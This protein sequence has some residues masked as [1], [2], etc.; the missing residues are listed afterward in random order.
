M[1]LEINAPKTKVMSNNT[2]LDA[3]LTVTGETLECVDSLTYLGSVI[4]RDWNVQKDIN[5]RLGKAM[6]AFANLR[7]L[8]LS[9]V[10]SIRIKLNLYDSIVKSVLLYGSEYWQVVETDFHK[11][12]AFHN[13]CLRMI[14]RILWSR[15]ISNLELYAKK[16]SEP[17]QATIKKRRLRWL[18]QFLRMSQNRI[19]RVALRCMFWLETM[20]IVK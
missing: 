18:G 7:P 1:G 10:Y 12:E 8:W 2:T 17:I 5:N 6:D 4:S 13:G 11:I 15:T 20:G 14:C 9:S 16:N 3:P 19:P